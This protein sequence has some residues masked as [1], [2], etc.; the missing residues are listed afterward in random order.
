MISRETPQVSGPSA[1][2]VR[3]PVSE[4]RQVGGPPGGI[5]CGG[6]EC[7]VP[8]RTPWGA[9]GDRCLGGVQLGGQAFPGMDIWE[10]SGW[11]RLRC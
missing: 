4:S 5:G 6:A 8:M 1:L 10:S 9:P 11:S 3:A 2:E 7:E